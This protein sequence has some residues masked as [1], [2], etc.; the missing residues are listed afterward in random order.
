MARALSRVGETIVTKYK[1]GK[2]ERVVERVLCLLTQHL[3]EF[4]A[5]LGWQ[6]ALCGKVLG[7]PTKLSWLRRVRVG[8]ERHDG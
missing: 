4:D 3:P 5:D 6:C 1:S 2:L 8:G 7:R